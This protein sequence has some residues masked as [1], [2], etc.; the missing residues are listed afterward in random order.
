MRMGSP[1][2]GG[3]RTAVLLIALSTAVWGCATTLD[4]RKVDESGFLGDY[5]KLKQV[6]EGEAL[7]VYRNP[8]VDLGSYNKVIIDPVEL[9]CCPESKLREA[10]PEELE[11]L[12]RTLVNTLKRSLARRY[13]I[14]DEPGPGVMRL[15]A[16]LTEATKSVV[17]LD[18]FST[19]YPSA[20]ILSEAKKM[21]TGVEAFVGS[22]SI[23]IR[24]VDSV[25]NQVLFEEADRRGG[26][27]SI[28][29]LSKDPW[30][31]VELIF[32]YWSDQLADELQ[33]KTYHAQAGE[34]AP[35][36]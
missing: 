17:L 23:E 5:S 15:H 35:S 33:G 1:L 10:S 32:E 27:K 34:A 31:D 8:D 13:E 36:K 18:A 6:K 26:G 9:W 21:A 29:K 2:A 4:A 24:A 28:K 3:M 14:V 16:A 20:R 12:S 7:L 19:V 25:T 30:H 11:R 22:A